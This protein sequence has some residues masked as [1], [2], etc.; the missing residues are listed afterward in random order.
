MKKLKQEL[1]EAEHV[2]DLKTVIALSRSINLHNRAALEVFRKYGLTIAQFG[3]LE[4]LYHKGPM[5]IGE[6]TEKI[7]STAGNMTVVIQNLERNGL[8][9]CRQ[10]PIDRRARLVFLTDQGA[11]ILQELFPSYLEVVR[12]VFSPLSDEEKQIVTRLLKKL[13]K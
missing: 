12:N 10:H 9:D 8:I 4:A 3:V 2:Q 5:K 6:I 11:N 1:Y 13:I 7:L